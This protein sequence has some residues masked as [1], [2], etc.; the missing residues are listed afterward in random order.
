M[1][2]SVLK[3]PIFKGIVYL[4]FLIIFIRVMIKDI[5]LSLLDFD[6]YYLSFCRCLVYV[7]NFYLIQALIFDLFDFTLAIVITLYIFRV[8]YSAD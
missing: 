6:Y 7:D 4:C 3:N 2:S 5:V 1:D 8:A